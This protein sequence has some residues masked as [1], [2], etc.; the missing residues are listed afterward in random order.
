MAF[1]STTIRESR[2]IIIWACTI[3]PGRPALPLTT[4]TITWSIGISITRRRWVRSVRRRES[5]SPT[6]WTFRRCSCRGCSNSRRASRR[7]RSRRN[8]WLPP[9]T[10]ITKIIFLYKGRIGL[11][12]LTQARSKSTEAASSVKVHPAKRS[13]LPEARRYTREYTLRLF[14]NTSYV[15]FRCEILWALWGAS[16]RAPSINIKKDSLPFFSLQI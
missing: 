4:T 9:P 7:R 2:T 6:E 15:T 3:S 8:T 5:S 14:N 11:D 1:P 10:P 13:E 16:K 12:E